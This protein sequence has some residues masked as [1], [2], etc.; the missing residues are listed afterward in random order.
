[1]VR[2]D[3]FDVGRGIAEVGRQP[4]TG[5]PFRCRD[6]RQTECDGSVEERRV[7]HDDPRRCA[8]NLGLTHRVR[9]DMGLRHRGR[10]LGDGRRRDRGRRVGRRRA[11]SST[12]SVVDDVRAGRLGTADSVTGAAVSAVVSPSSLPHAASDADRPPTWPRHTTDRVAR[13]GRRVREG[14]E[15]PANIADAIRCA[16]YLCISRCDHRYSPVDASMRWAATAC[17]SRSRSIT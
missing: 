13:A 6:R 5:D 3:E 14:P 10:R 4:G 8:R 11:Q 12:V 2:P 1:M 9:D 16:Y 17:S 7:E 15:H